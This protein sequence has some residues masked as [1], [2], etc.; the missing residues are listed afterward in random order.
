MKK[1][2][3]SVDGKHDDELRPEYQ[4]DYRQTRPNP[5][6]GR[7]KFTHGGPRPGAG[8]RARFGRPMVRKTIRLSEQ[9]VAHLER[10]GAGNLSEGVR[11]A[12]RQARARR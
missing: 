11:A 9:D 4:I 10:L 8:R 12:L 3:S 7:V 1:G 2:K 6:A 5:Y